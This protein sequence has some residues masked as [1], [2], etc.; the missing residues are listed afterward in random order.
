MTSPNTSS[1]PRIVIS[2][3]WP[4]LDTVLRIHV[5]DLPPR[6]AVTLRATQR[7]P[8]DCVWSSSATFESQAD[9]SVDLHRDAPN[10]GS[11]SGTDPMGLIWSMEAFDEPVSASPA[12]FLAPTTLTVA[13]EIHGE[14]VCTAHA[15]R[16]RVPDGLCRTEVR[17]HGLVGTLYRPDD[18]RSRPGVLLLGGSEG[19]MHE[20][21]AALLAAHGYAVLALAYYGMPGLP[22]TLQDIPL[23]YF[24]QALRF[25]RMHAHVDGERLTVMGV[26]KGG[27]AALL[28]GAT[29]REP[30]AVISMVGSGLI[31]QGIS[32]DVLTGSFLDIMATP[33]ASWT[34]QGRGLTYLPNVVTAELEA[35]V[36]AGTPIALRMAFEPALAGDHL[37]SAVTIPVERINGPVLLISGEHDQGYGPEVHHVAAQ[38]LAT[39]NHSYQHIVYPGAGHLIAAPPYAPTTRSTSPGPGVTFDHGGTPA[40]NA[41]ARADAWQQ[42]IRFLAAHTGR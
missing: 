18:D 20:D 6:T 16:L 21:D 36:A 29:F 14:Q 32:Q 34:Y 33:V 39:N 1:R 38:R 28:I 8:Y 23:E 35:A 13:A 19:G 2:P 11:Y 4:H 17:E 10:S 12:D 15:H 37:L 42:T 26:S 3:R 27:E 40:A 30:C 24:A 25:L 41:H 7:D 22:S 9:G 31:T 5:F